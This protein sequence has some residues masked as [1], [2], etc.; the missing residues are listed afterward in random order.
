TPDGFGSGVEA[1]LANGQLVVRVLSG[2]F[3]GNKTI[4]PTRSEQLPTGVREQPQ[5]V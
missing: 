3:T 2:D 1:S 4:Q 5:N